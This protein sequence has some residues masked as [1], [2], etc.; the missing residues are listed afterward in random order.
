MDFACRGGSVDLSVGRPVAWASG[1]A[2]VAALGRGLVRSGTP[3]GCGAGN[4]ATIS[5]AL[6]T[7]WAVSD[8]MATVW[9]RCCCAAPSRSSCRASG[10]GRPPTTRRPGAPGGL[11]RERAS[12]TTRPR[13]LPTRSFSS[14]RWG[15]PWRGWCDLRA[16]AR[17]ACRWWPC[18]TCGTR[19]SPR[20]SRGPRSRFVPS[21]TRG[22]NWSRGRP[23]CCMAWANRW[24]GPTEPTPSGRS[25]RVLS[26]RAWWWS[27][28]CA[29]TLL[30]SV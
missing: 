29:K 10:C 8:A 26:G 24:G 7:S 12:I 19:T 1:V 15:A 21:S 5:R 13:D 17:S 4:A 16:G 23:A 9:P 18:C 30:S 20:S 28:G 27:A 11:S 22:R 3:A 14:A 2:V 25:C 6:I